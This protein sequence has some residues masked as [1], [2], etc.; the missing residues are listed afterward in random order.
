MR[1]VQIGDI[2]RLSRHGYSHEYYVAK[3]TD[4][5]ATLRRC[6]GSKGVRFLKF[7]GSHETHEVEFLRSGIQ[8]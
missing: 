1:Q 3:L 6:D 2:Y 4:A 8:L 7:D 5:K